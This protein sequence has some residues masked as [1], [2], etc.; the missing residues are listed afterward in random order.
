MWFSINVLLYLRGGGGGGRLTNR[1]GLLDNRCALGEWGLGIISS[2]IVFEKI[3]V[4]ENIYKKHHW[5]S[6]VEWISPE[7][8]PSKYTIE[9]SA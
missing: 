9:L 8:N 6:K 2:P 1:P 7:E 3:E 5:T 4:L